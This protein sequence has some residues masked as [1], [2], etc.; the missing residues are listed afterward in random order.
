M[1]IGHE[2]QCPQ[3]A[4]AEEIADFSMRRIKDLRPTLA[5][6]PAQTKRP[7]KKIPEAAR[8]RIAPLTS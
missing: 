2:M 3:R 5:L 1:R 8:M 4:R 6:N 7:P